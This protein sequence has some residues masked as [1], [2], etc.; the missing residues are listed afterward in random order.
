MKRHPGSAERR[1][2]KEREVI[3][4]A[5]AGEIKWIQAADILRVTARTMRRKRE[6][7]RA[8]GIRG[9]I[10]KR[11]GSLSPRRAPYEV[12]EK[13]LR[14]Y[15]EE[16]FDFNIKHFHEHLVRDHGVEYS[17]TWT[18]NLLQEAGYVK[19]Q[20]GRGGHRRR[21]ER[22]PIFGQM[23]HLD[24]SDHEWLSLRPG[25]RQVLLLVI[26]DATGQ[27]LAG[28]LEAAETTKACLSIMRVVVE[29]HGIPAQLYT[30]R[31]SV[32][33]HTKKAGGK[34]DRE[35]LTQFGQVMEELGIEM[36]PSYS[37]QAR[38]RSER[39]NGTWQGRLLAELRKAGINNIKEA[40][41]YIN[42][43]F[44]P[45]MNQRFA[46][47]ARETG[48]A[49]VSA[50]GANLDRIF[51]IRYQDRTVANDNTVQVNNLKLQIEKSPF[52]VNFCQCKVNVFQHLDGTYT[53]EWN[54]RIIGRYD[55][56]GKNLLNQA[57]GQPPDP[58]GLT[59]QRPGKKIKK[60]RQKQTA[61]ASSPVA[62][63]PLGSLPSVAL[64]SHGA[65]E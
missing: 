15:R 60:E 4:K 62:P 8:Y 44:L 11:R 9:L 7:L 49:F 16:Y 20:K 33:W 59:L 24:G 56:K 41:V 48:S 6:A 42:E 58:R 35:N 50:E 1:A 12:V 53:A 31:D 34:V 39:W 21:R 18:K 29:K 61:P 22:R 10:D 52:R 23:L 30:D 57:G 17:Y 47:E 54:K 55:E 25:E 63:R 45:E 2:M 36:I 38:G 46:V 51:S 64:S 5:I 3:L 40:N 43:V 26:D 32:Y 27:N 28:R 65:I 37:P 14:L 13:V 19:R